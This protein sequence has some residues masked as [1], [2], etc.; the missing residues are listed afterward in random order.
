MRG[1]ATCAISP[2]TIPP[3]PTP[4]FIVRRCWANAACRREAGVRR[5]IS[6]D[7]LGQKPAEP[8][9][10]IAI[11][12]K[13]CQGSRTSGS[14]PKPIA[15]ST[16]PQPS[17]TRGPIRSIRCPARIPATSSAA[18]E[19]PTIRPAVPSPNPRTSCR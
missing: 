7:W 13:A 4:R 19:T 9:P 14:S 11:S 18:D 17:V 3:R 15:W 6:V 8:A 5:E 1:F 12:T 2:P 10:S 16:R